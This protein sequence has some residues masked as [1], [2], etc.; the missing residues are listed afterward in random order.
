M[1]N[2]LMYERFYYY[3]DVIHADAQVTLKLRNN[4]TIV[5][6]DLFVVIIV[7]PPPPP[8]A[9]NSKK[10]DKKN[11]TEQQQQQQQQLIKR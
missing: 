5:A 10:Q 1:S 2:W 7:V 11:L 6:I 9:I 3:C 4:A 8:S